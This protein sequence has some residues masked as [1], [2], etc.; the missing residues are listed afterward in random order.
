MEAIELVTNYGV[1]INGVVLFSGTFEEC[2]R[3]VRSISDTDIAH[4][5]QIKIL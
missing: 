5:A 3:Y 2:R 1:I 4:L